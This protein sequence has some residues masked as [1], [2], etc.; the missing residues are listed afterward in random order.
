MAI[1]LGRIDENPF[2]FFFAGTLFWEFRGLS[3]YNWTSRS[4]PF[5]SGFDFEEVGD[6][7]RALELFDLVIQRSLVPWLS[8]DLFFLLSLRLQFVRFA[9]F[10]KLICFDLVKW[11]LKGTSDDFLIVSPWCMA[12][13]CQR[14]VGSVLAANN[15]E[16]YGPSFHFPTCSM[17]DVC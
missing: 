6:K 3:S 8:F 7:L 17:V 12:K 14:N 9:P 4:T 1:L 15:Q 2:F 10:R 5:L 11:K 13:G 16:P